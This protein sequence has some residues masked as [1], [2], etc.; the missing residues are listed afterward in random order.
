MLDIGT[1]TGLWA[2]EMADL[3]P[4]ATV[5]GTDLSPVQPNWYETIPQAVC[6][7]MEGLI[8]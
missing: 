6:S 3:F 1:G 8:A 2:I 7:E 4:N 5:I